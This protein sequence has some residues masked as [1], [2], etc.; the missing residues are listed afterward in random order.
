M[1]ISKENGII[2]YRT[3]SK[4]SWE[5]INLKFHYFKKVSHERI[6]IVKK[7]SIDSIC[8]TCRIIK[9]SQLLYQK[10]QFEETKLPLFTNLNSKSPP[11][12]TFQ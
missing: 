8:S 2:K 9:F 3:L 11:H 5:K 7:T 1:Y 6:I 4:N 12:K 10:Y